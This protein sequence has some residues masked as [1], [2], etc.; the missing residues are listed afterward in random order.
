MALQYIALIRKD[1]DTDYWVD[2]PDLPGRV[3]SGK[4]EDEAKANFKEALRLHIEALRGKGNYS[5]P[6]PRSYDEVF[7]EEQESYI[8]DFISLSRLS[9][10]IST[11][12]HQKLLLGNLVATSISPVNLAEQ[13]SF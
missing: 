8:G 7:S 10:S 4:N 12:Y 11:K 1:H 13:G 5:L 3:A 6:E 9:H 2:I